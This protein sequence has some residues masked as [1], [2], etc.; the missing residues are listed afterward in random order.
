ML[1]RRWRSC[2]NLQSIVLG[3]DLLSLAREHGREPLGIEHIHRR[4]DQNSAF[5]RTHQ[6]T[7]GAHRDLAGTAGVDDRVK[8]PVWY[9]APAA[10][11]G[12]EPGWS[13]VSDAPNSELV[14]LHLG[15][16]QRRLERHRRA[17][18]AELVGVEGPAAI[19][20]DT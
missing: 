16:D 19:E 14:V 4:I 3:A 12:R 2:L 6:L 15:S 8:G 11:G 1:H 20:L 18:A 5:D 17:Q 10:P 7:G 13:G 9:R